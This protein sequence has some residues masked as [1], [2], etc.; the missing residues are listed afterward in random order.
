M[1][2]KLSKRFKMNL[3]KIFKGYD[4]VN[5]LNKK[6]HHYWNDSIYFKFLSHEIS[7]DQSG[8]WYTRPC[9][10]LTASQFLFTRSAPSSKRV[11]ISTGFLVRLSFLASVFY[12]TLA[13]LDYC[14]CQTLQLLE[15]DS[16]KKLD[17]VDTT[18]RKGVGDQT[19][20]KLILTEEIRAFTGNSILFN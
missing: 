1:G 16:S 17:A 2:K 15:E 7:K 12:F 6:N 3:I 14:V 19:R 8:I 13:P 10:L 18:R 11:K 20:F 4:K 5:F 9:I